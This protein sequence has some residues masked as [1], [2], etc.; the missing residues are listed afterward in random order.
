[1]R[2]DTAVV[3][4]LEQPARGSVAP[5]GWNSP[6]ELA[7]RSSPAPPTSP[8]APTL[9]P[10]SATASGAAAADAAV[11]WRMRAARIDNLIVYGGYLTVCL[12][13]HW[14]VTSLAHLMWLGVAGVAYHFGLEVRDGQT[15][16]KRRYGIRVVAVDGGPAGARAIAIRNVLRI[17]DSLPVSYLA[18]LLSMVRSGP[19]RRQRIGDIA[20]GTI[21]VA[22][23]GRA[24][25]DGTPGWMLPVAT[26]A[27]VIASALI[28]MT[29]AQVGYEPLS[30]RQASQLVTGCETSPSGAFPFACRH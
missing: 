5:P 29:I 14:R 23:D 4:F 2:P 15:L 27:A 30:S 1:M 19:S 18:G 24:A 7:P 9:T 6:P 20:A 28:V 25:R 13:L 11:R 3:S 26:I 8:A 17:V 21:V 16:G 22:V 10:S 12:L